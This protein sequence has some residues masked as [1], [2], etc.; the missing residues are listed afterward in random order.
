MLKQT[1]GDDDNHKAL[2][3]VAASEGRALFGAA[4]AGPAASP[5]ETAK[6]RL[7]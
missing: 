5:M 1:V 2:L 3:R 7:G 6:N 4:V